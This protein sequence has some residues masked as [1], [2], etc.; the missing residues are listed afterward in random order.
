MTR[1][2]AGTILLLAFLSLGTNSISAQ[3]PAFANRVQAV[4]Y[5]EDLGRIDI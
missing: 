4:R 2:T 3:E 5:E 1:T